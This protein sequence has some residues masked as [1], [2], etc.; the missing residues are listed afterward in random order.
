MYKKNKTIIIIIAS[1]LSIL[2]AIVLIGFF[3]ADRIFVFFASKFISPSKPVPI[4]QLMPCGGFPVETIELGSP[5]LTNPTAEFTT[6]GGFIY[7]VARRFEHAGIFGSLRGSTAIYTGLA[8][9][10]P[11][12][13]SQK[14][15]VSNIYQQISVLEKDY[16]RLDLPAGRYWLWSSSGGDIV[17]YSCQEGILSDPK[18]VK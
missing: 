2:V 12:W 17:L 5:Y 7:V 4:E 6:T 14:N 1:I 11:S 8:N 18:P 15:I 3:F 10:P 16:G 13:D 9:N